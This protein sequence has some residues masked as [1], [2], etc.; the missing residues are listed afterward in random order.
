MSAMRLGASAFLGLSVMASTVSCVDGSLPANQ[1]PAE[2][3]SLGGASGMGDVPGAGASGKPNV[4]SAGASGAGVPVATCTAPQVSCNGV[5]VDLT[6]P[7]HCGTCEQ[8]CVTG[9]SCTAGACV[10]PGAQVACNGACVDTQTSLEHCG[11]C[12]KPCATGAACSAG[13]CGCAQ[14]QELCNGV[15]VDVKESEANCGSCGN[16]CMTGQTCSNGACLIGAGAD[17]CSGGPAL[18]ISLKRIDVYQ[19]VKVPVMDSGTEITTDKRT[20]DVVAGRP[21]MFRISV[22]LDSGFSARQISARVTVDNGGTLAQYFAK[23]AVSKD[24]VETDTASTFQVLVP[25]E[26]ITVDTRYSAELVE[27]ATGTGVAGSARFPKTDATALAARRVGGLKVTIVPLQANNKLPD[28]SETAL[29]TYRQQLLAMYPIDAVTFTVAPAVTVAYP[30]DWEGT[31]DQMRAKRRTD[32]PAADV[33]YYG[34]LKPVDSFNSFCGNGC[35]TGIG[36]VGD[37]NSGGYRVAMGVGFADRVSA[38]TLAHELGH[39]HGRGHAPCVPNGGSI[40]GVDTKYPFADGRI[41]IIGYDSR[42]KALLSEKGTD[43]M[44]YCSNVWLSEYTYDALMTRVAL[45]NAN[46]SQVLSAAALQTWRVLLVGGSRGPRWGVP[47]AKPSLPEGT[48]VSARIVDGA[49]N[50]LQEI[51]VYR[52]EI[53]DSGAASIMVPEPKQGWSGVEVMGSGVVA[54]AP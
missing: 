46:K 32:A 45:V 8:A 42:T 29:T 4:S 20:T 33:Y 6:S 21:T 10:C 49:G 27:C 9:Q 17:G 39:N 50:L 28:T 5:C 13:A 19:T 37:A 36:F 30:V 26:Q 40:S 1:G 3:V 22:A 14:G 44:G 2:H 16:A 18:G 35:T 31:L 48:A 34:L 41:G 47:I 25:A 15:C 11:G 12:S 38:Q 52:T 43:L 54:F 23:Q 24:S 51:T 7:A 53:S